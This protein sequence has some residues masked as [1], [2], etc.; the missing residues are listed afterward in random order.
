MAILTWIQTTAGFALIV[1]RNIEPEKAAKLMKPFD[2]IE[3]NYAI[4]VIT[5]ILKVKNVSRHFTIPKSYKF[6]KESIQES[7]HSFAGT[8][9]Q[10]ISQRLL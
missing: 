2:M 6:T 1:E 5:L 7:Y 3:E 10:D 4:D 8:A 9:E